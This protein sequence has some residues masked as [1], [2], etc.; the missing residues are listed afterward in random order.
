MVSAAEAPFGQKYGPAASAA[1]PA[2]EV[3]TNERRLIDMSNLLPIARCP[4]ALA[5]LRRTPMALVTVTSPPRRRKHRIPAGRRAGV[6]VPGL[7]IMR[8]AARPGR[9][10]RRCSSVDAPGR[11]CQTGGRRRKKRGGAAHENH[12]IGGRNRHCG[13]RA[14]RRSAC[15]QQLEHGHGLSRSVLPHQEHPIASSKRIEAQ[16]KGD[17]RIT[18]HSASSLFKLPE[19]GRA[20]QTGQI[21]MGETVVSLLANEDR[22]YE[23][24]FAPVLRRDLRPGPAAVAGVQTLYRRAP[25]PEG[26]HPAV[27]RSRG[28]R[29]AST[30]RRNW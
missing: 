9:Q 17:V 1:A 14:G 28:R 7:P 2:A 15:G 25:G 4:A 30:P 11:W 19:I 29:R 23:V 22:V 18:V 24:D 8:R 3:L 21:E 10:P 27:F 20:V 12:R 16:T 26:H 6:S 13:L 5:P